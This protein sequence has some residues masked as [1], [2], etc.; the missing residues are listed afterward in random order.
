MQLDAA[1]RLKRYSGSELL[2]PVPKK[3]LP[4]RY[5]IPSSARRVVNLDSRKVMQDLRVLLGYAPDTEASRWLQRYLSIVGANQPPRFVSID[6]EYSSARG[7]LSKFHLG[8]SIFDTRT[9]EAFREDSLKENDSEPA[10]QSHQYVVND[11]S[12]FIK[13][14]SQFS[15]GAPETISLSNLAVKLKKLVLPPIILVAH[16]PTKERRVLR[17]LGIRLGLVDVFDT[18]LMPRELLQV[19]YAPS[20]GGLLQRLGIPYEEHLL[21][22]AGNDARFTLQ[23]LLMMI[24]MDAERYLGSSELPAWVSTFRAIAQAKPPNPTTLTPT[25]LTPTTLTPTESSEAYLLQK[26]ENRRLRRRDRRHRRYEEERLQKREQRRLREEAASS[27]GP[28]E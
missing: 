6:T 1:D 17:Q 23:A 24:A 26:R 14:A 8:L 20:L 10:V 18:A 7:P 25:T 4:L 15:F 5:R 13:K 9:L 22:V 3:Q 21:H 27:T 16:G 2:A 12:F 11:P 19:P 28:L